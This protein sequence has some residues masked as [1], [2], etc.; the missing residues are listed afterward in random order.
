MNTKYIVSLLFVTS[1]TFAQIGVGT[2]TPNA[3]AMLDITSTSKGFLQPRVAL[4]GTTDTATIVSPATG[5]MVFN[6]ATAGS[7]AAA[8]TPGVYYHNG[9]AWQR[10]ANQAE[11]TAAT[12]STPTTFVNGNLGNSWNGD[13]NGSYDPLTSL[14]AKNFGASITLPPG[15]WEVNLVLNVDLDTSLTMQPAPTWMNYW[16]D[17][18][19]PTNSLYYEQIIN[20]STIGTNDALFTG[21]ASFVR[22]V[23]GFASNHSGV[24]YI[25][26]ATQAN[27]TY[28]LYFFESLPYNGCQNMDCIRILY[29]K[30]GGTTGW[31]GNRFYATKIN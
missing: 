21:A 9:T 26:N 7:G 14:G 5:L 22:P 25:N 31:P 18:N 8:V 13:M 2:S 28:T 11:L 23:G 6:T 29:K 24:F 19:V 27:K 10:V 1:I 20:G 4:T 16:L 17:E 12:A 30:F 15:K 3:S